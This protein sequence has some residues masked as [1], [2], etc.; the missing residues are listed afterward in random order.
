VVRY[1]VTFILYRGPCLLLIADYCANEYKSGKS[2][3]TSVD[4][5]A[6]D[7][8]SHMISLETTP[9]HSSTNPVEQPIDLFLNR[10]AYRT[11]LHVRITAR[12]VAP[13]VSSLFNRPQRH[14]YACS[15]A[16]WLRVD[17]SLLYRAAS[18]TLRIFTAFSNQSIR[19][20]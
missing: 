3:P 14:N 1:E 6:I 15:V 5:E 11:F 2:A 10:P 16:R 7:I 19:P 8:T 20:L 4:L 17:T 12:P 13:L 9:T 18:T